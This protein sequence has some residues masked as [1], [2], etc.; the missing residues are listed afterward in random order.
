VIK[1][2]PLEEEEQQSTALV[3]AHTGEVVDLGDE[4]QIAKAYKEVKALQYALN[5]GLRRLRSAMGERSSV[6]LTKTIYVDGVGKV[7]VKNTTE[8]VWDADGLMEA[9]R[10]AEVPEEIIGEIVT[11]TIT[12]KVDA[13]RAKQAASANPKIGEII[14]AHKRIVPKIPDIS[15]S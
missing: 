15:I 13:A 9:L 4:R 2:R 5:E 1:I 14:E 7:Q 11:E 6:L 3:L 10:E 8:T 12:Y